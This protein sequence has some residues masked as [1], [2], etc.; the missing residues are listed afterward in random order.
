MIKSTIFQSMKIL[1]FVFYARANLLSPIEMSMKKK[2]VFVNP[3]AAHNVYLWRHYFF[4]CFFDFHTYHHDPAWPYGIHHYWRYSKLQRIWTNFIA[5]YK[6]SDLN[7]EKS[8]ILLIGDIFTNTLVYQFLRR[9]NTCFYSE[10]FLIHKSLWKRLFFM[11]WM[12]CFFYNKKILVP[13]A[14]SYQ[15]FRR[16]TKHIYYLPQLYSGK[17]LEPVLRDDG[18]IKLLFVWRMS[19]VYKNITFLLDNYLILKKHFPQLSLTLVWSLDEPAVFENYQDAI[20]NGDIIYL[21]QR[22][23]EELP[24]IFNT[25]D[26]FILP[27]VSD[28]IGAVV[29]EAMAH[30]CTVL[31]SDWVWASC[32]V[33]KWVSWYVFKSNDAVDFQEKIIT[34]IEHPDHLQ[35][36]KLAATKC[37][38]EKYS[39]NNESLCSRLRTELAL[40]FD[41]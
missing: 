20:D 11:V 31:V 25:H 5:R 28:P 29:Q 18:L 17:I 33:E 14:L 19:A 6:K 16:F 7:I 24:G 2:L 30:W 22:P 8:D 1:Y 37:I 10:F 23:Y 3:A 27:S 26:V 13:T 9:K 21:W 15:T 32:Y 40:F 34:F 38:Q 12:Y 35:E 36:S 41:Q 39:I 4:S